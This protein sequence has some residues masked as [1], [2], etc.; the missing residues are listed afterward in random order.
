MR[1]IRELKGRDVGLA[2]PLFALRSLPAWLLRHPVRTAH[3]DQ[4]VVDA[5]LRGGFV[6]LEEGPLEMIVGVIGRF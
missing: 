4:T 2:R 6:L 1:A 3:P 5:I